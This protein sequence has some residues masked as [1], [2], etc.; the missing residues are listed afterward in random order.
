MPQRPLRRLATSALVL[1]GLALAGPAP[2][3]DAVEEALATHFAFVSYSDGS[4]RPEQITPDLWD[5]FVIVDTRDAGQYKEDH[6]PGAIHVEWRTVLG[7]RDKLPRDK[8][9]LLYCN[10][11]S[12][13]A[14]A[15]L[16]LKLVGYDNVKV[17]AGGF[18][19]WKA[20]GG[21]EAYKQNQ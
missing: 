18:D 12:L 2:A 4:V 7:N 1:A 11:S 16:A 14:Q 6:I 17:L 5:R 13:S 19:A 3:S 8:P 20:K 9:L 21:F 15:A 10:T